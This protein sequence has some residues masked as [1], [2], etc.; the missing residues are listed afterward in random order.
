[1]YSVQINNLT[2]TSP[3]RALKSQNAYRHIFLEADSSWSSDCDGFCN[4]GGGWG[5]Y[6]SADLASN[7]SFCWNLGLGLSLGKC[8]TSR[9][10]DW[11]LHLHRRISRLLSVFY[12][13][14]QGKQTQEFMYSSVN[15]E[16][17]LAWAV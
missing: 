7:R 16:Q 6:Y 4:S 1:M 15:K 12:V 2:V 10:G 8:N 14:Q 9:G 11:S 17:V 5:G 13:L 3:V